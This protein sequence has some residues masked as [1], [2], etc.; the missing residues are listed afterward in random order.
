MGRPT[1]RTPGASAALSSVCATCAPGPTNPAHQWQGGTLHPDAAAR[2]DLRLRLPHQPPIASRP[3][4]LAAVVQ[5]AQTPQLARRPPAPQPRLT[6][7]WSL[8][9]AG[10]VLLDPLLAIT[11]PASQ[12]RE[13][14]VSV[15]RQLISPRFRWIR[16][17]SAPTSSYDDAESWIGRIARLDG[18]DDSRAG[19]PQRSSGRR[20]SASTSCRCRRCTDRSGHGGRRPPRSAP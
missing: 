9:L 12:V 5:Q 3:L 10:A 20:G 17:Y 2:L 7:P 18:M 1:S 14:P 8:H 19:R 4:R 13:A 6:P 15:S 11:P 16:V